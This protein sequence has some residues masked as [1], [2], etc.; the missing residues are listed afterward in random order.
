MGRKLKNI[1]TII[2][3]IIILFAIVAL[4]LFILKSGVFK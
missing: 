4:I 2:G 1:L 3:W